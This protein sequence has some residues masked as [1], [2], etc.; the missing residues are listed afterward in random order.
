MAR[1]SSPEML[2]IMT[3]RS[4]NAAMKS[5]AAAAIAARPTEGG[6]SL[7]VSDPSVR[8]TLLQLAALGC[9]M[10]RCTGGKFLQ[11]KARMHHAVVS[12][13]IS[14]SVTIQERGR[15]A[16]GVAKFWHESRRSIPQ[17]L[18]FSAIN[19]GLFHSQSHHWID[20]TRPS[21]SQVTSCKRNSAQ[22]Q[23]DSSKRLRIDGP[24]AIQQ[25]L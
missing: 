22:Y 12:S 16:L 24:S 7:I 11:V 10:R 4:G 6:P 20:S 13:S 3:F 23:R 2:S 19:Q 8:R 15:R 1:S 5:C 25:L 18:G 17:L 21:C 9:T 14:A